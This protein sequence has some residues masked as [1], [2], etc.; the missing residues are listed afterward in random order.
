MLQSC[1]REI[2]MPSAPAVFVAEAGVATA[3]KTTHN[4]A[5]CEY[6]LL[7]ILVSIT[8][9]LKEPNYRLSDADVTK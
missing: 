8:S 3:N 4:A 9:V 7:R 5:I 6:M 1:P 2:Q